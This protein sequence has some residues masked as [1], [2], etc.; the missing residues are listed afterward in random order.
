MNH[1]LLFEQ[2]EGTLAPVET[3]ILYHGSNSQFDEFDDSKMSTGETGDLFGK[4]YY[5]TDS[6]AVAAHYGKATAKKAKITKW[7]DDG[8]LGSSRA[9]YS[10]DAD[11]YAN[12]NHHVNSFRVQGRFL[13]ATTYVM[14]DAMVD[15]IK[16]YFVGI[17]GWGA[18]EIDHIVTYVRT[19]RERIKNFRGELLYIIQ[20]TPEDIAPAIVEQVKRMG[21]DGVKYPSDGHY[22]GEGSSNY[23]VYNRSTISKA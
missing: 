23:V 14:D 16:E 11:S 6:E 19:K 2:F 15:A 7:T 5:L 20:Q 17:S 12:A 21:Y 3:L 13:D 9:H 18:G 8:I 4:G 1:L 10:K 22:E